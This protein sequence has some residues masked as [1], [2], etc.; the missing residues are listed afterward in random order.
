MACPRL[1]SDSDLCRFRTKPCKRSKQ[2]GCDFGI[3]RCQYSHNIYWPRRCPFYLSNESTIRYIPVLC[4]DII[5]KEDES[6]V[7]HCNRGGGCPFAHSFEEVNYHPLIYKTKLCDQFQRG[8]CNTYYCHL[9]HGLA[10]RREPKIYILPYTQNVNVPNYPGVVIANKAITKSMGSGGGSS[11]QFIE[12]E[13]SLM[14]KNY[15]NNSSDINSAMDNN[16]SNRNGLKMVMRNIG[17]GILRSSL[18]NLLGDNRWSERIFSSSVASSPINSGS[19]CEEGSNGCW[20]NNGG[21]INNTESEV[22]SQDENTRNESIMNVFRALVLDDNTIISKEDLGKNIQGVGIEVGGQ[23]DKVVVNEVKGTSAS[24]ADVSNNIKINDNLTS[25]TVV[26]IKN[27]KTV[28]NKNSNISVEEKI[29]R[30][31]P[32]DML[33]NENSNKSNLKSQ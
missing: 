30:N 16:L 13:K 24:N 22:N 9:I 10:E 11:V 21:D 31:N 25:E 19:V 8:D 26:S 3:S 33:N 23:N 7:S 18:D 29:N 14:H 6:S 32:T 5:I 4:P 27:T 15:A 17:D 2:M 28:G 1:L 20:G 12:K